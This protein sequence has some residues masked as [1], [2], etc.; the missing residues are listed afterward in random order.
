MRIAT[1]S[2]QGRALFGDVRVDLAPHKAL[3]KN[4][5][6]VNPPRS[7][8]ER[9]LDGVMAYQQYYNVDDFAVFYDV[10]LDAVIDFEQATEISQ[11]KM[12]IDAG[13]HRQ[14]HPPISV[15][16]LTSNDGENWQSQLKMKA[17][18]IKGPLLT[19]NFSPVT[20][21]FVRVIA[22][23]AKNSSDAQIP[24]LPLYIDEIAVY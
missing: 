18:E 19:L 8:I 6:F 2:A 17:E 5:S 24:E 11:V 23:N 13:R 16:V 12:G 15:E 7:G 4:I 3:G 22:V 21:R 14:L 1:E 20:Q 10:D 9:I